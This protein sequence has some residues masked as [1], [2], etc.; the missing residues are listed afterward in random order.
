MLG[1]VIVSL[2]GS[3]CF[4]SQT[5]LPPGSQ[6]LSPLQAWTGDLGLGRV[7]SGGVWPSGPGWEPA[8][9]L[10]K[11]HLASQSRAE[12]LFIAPGTWLVYFKPHRSPRRADSKLRGG[13]PGPSS[14]SLSNEVSSILPTLPGPYPG[15]A[16]HEVLHSPLQPPA[17]VPI[18]SPFGRAER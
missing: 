11:V 2:L 5:P 12:P 17:G 7:G 8:R 1:H 10:G 18:I 6:S 3:S 9:S 4:P 14:H 16:W 13:A 15:P